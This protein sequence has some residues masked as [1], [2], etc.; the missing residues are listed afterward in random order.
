MSRI[1]DVR[2]AVLHEGFIFAGRNFDAKLDLHRYSDLKL[3]YDRDEKE[4][5]VSYNGEVLNMPHTNVK[6]YQIGEFKSRYAPQ[7]SHPQVANV[8]ITAQVET[9]HSHVHAG[10]GAVKRAA[11]PAKMQG[12]SV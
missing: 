3:Q 12:E 7:V 11:K 4:L 5:L 1:V 6:G 8:A 2:F 10:P 9:P